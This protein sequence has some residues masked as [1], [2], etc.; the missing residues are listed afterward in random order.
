MDRKKERN[1]FMKCE[2]QDKRK[3]QNQI[4]ITKKKERKYRE[5]SFFIVASFLF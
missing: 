4:R 1:Q 3:Y 5:T 2:I